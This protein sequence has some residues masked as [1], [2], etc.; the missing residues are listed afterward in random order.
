MSRNQTSEDDMIDED[1]NAKLLVAAEACSG[2]GCTL[3]AAME[4]QIRVSNFYKKKPHIC[5][6]SLRLGQ[7]T[8]IC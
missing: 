5:L 8:F 3:P 4:M 6:F 2:G 1:I 7:L